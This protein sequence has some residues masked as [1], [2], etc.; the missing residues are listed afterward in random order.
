M[1]EVSCCTSQIALL[2]QH[3]R[4]DLASVGNLGLDS[5]PRIGSCGDF[6]VTRELQLDLLARWS[7]DDIGF[8]NHLENVFTASILRHMEFSS[9][10]ETSPLTVFEDGDP[11]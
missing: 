10:A 5:V 1:T 8:V 11:N 3:D 4:Q 6:C 9:T 2:D 7:G